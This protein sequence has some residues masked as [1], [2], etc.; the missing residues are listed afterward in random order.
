MSSNPSAAKAILILTDNL[1][2]AADL[3]EQIEQ[4]KLGRVVVLRTLSE[5]ALYLN[6]SSEPPVL[7]IF[8]LDRRT[9]DSAATVALLTERGC[10]ILFIDGGAEDRSATLVATGML[11]PYTSADVDA[12]LRRLGLWS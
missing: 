10:R 6:G 2:E 9:D 1:L 8:G 7:V 4:R 12:A 11:R 3:T 5:A